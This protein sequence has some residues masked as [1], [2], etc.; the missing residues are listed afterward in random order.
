VWIEPWGKDY[1]LLLG[2]TF[3]VPTS[4]SIDGTAPWFNLVETEGNTQVF[5]ERGTSPKL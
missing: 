2:E 1:T 5:V 4:D 3:L